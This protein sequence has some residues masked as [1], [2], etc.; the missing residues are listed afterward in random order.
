MHIARVG[1]RRGSYRVLEGKPERR[2]PFEKLWF[3]WEDNI[4]TNL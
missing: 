3:K 4:K 2:R 1:K